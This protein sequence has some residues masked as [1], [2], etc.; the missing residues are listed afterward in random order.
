MPPP[1]K[2]IVG[3]GN[4]GR[5]Y[6]TTRHNVGF[7]VLAELARRYATEKP[8]LKFQGEIAP[9]AIDGVRVLLLAPQ[10][11]MNNSGRSVLAARDFYKIEIENLLVVCDDFH[12]PPGKLRARRSGSSGGQKGL[13]DVVRVLGT[14]E[15]PRLRIGVGEVPDAWD[16]A[17]WVLSKFKK[18][19]QAEIELAVVL[20]ADA[21][22]AW[23]R[24]GIDACMNRFN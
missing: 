17:D 21:A 15:V 22:V 4:P 7:T 3:L 13:A 10:T 11:Y 19:E 1:E 2:I 6:Q 20:A 24:E 18:H 8:K 23:V 14:D 12:L 5:R 9:A 16:P